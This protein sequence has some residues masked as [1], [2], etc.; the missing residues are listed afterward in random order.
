MK[1]VKIQLFSGRLADCYEVLFQWILC[2]SHLY[3][4]NCVSVILGRNC[5]F[6]PLELRY[7]TIRYNGLESDKKFL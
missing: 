5:Y 3:L 7:F 1:V 6:F 4:L 2:I